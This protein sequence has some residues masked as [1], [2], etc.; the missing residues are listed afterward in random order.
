MRRTLARGWPRV[1]RAIRGPGRSAP[2]LF[3]VVWRVGRRARTGDSRMRGVCS[4]GRV[5]AATFGLGLPPQ[6]HQPRKHA[7][8]AL[9]LGCHERLAS[10][11]AYAP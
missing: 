2:D 7:E 3:G 6:A 10:F 5:A 9:L 4:R 1:R 8:V 11:L